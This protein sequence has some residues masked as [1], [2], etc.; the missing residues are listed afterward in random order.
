VV[1]FRLL[2]PIEVEGNVGQLVELGPPRQ[3]SVLAALAVDAGKLVMVDSLVDR[4]WGESP[5]ARVQHAIYSYV[6]RL[7]AILAGEP[8]APALVRRSRGYL[9]D[10]DPGSVDVHRFH[11]LLAQARTSR[12]PDPVRADLLRGGL[13]L[14][15][16]SPLAEMPGEWAAGLRHVWGQQRLEAVVLWAGIEL[17]TGNPAVVIDTLTG[18]VAEHPLHEP[19][20]C[21]LMRALHASGRVGDALACYATVRA[22]L[23]DE[24]GVDPSAELR[25]VHQSILDGDVVSR[26]P[27]VAAN[28]GG[29][30]PAQLPADVAGFTGRDLELAV[31]G[32]H[33]ATG[34]AAMVISAIAGTAGVGKTA[35]AVRFA[36]RVRDRFPDGQLH[37][38]LRGY[39]DN[40]PMGPGDV[41]AAFLRALGVPG[42]GI[43]A[44]VEERAA[45]YR[46]L[47]NG[48]RMV[49]LLDNASS[50]EQISPLL[51]GSPSCLVLVTSRDSLAGLVARHGARR[52]DLDVLSAREARA[53]LRG[54]VGTRVDAEPGAADAL[55]VQCGRL[56]LAL[57]VVAELA[58]TRQ[59]SSLAELAEELSDGRQRLDAFDVGSGIRAV[60]AF[61]YRQLP[62]E[63]ARAFRL[64]GL[65]PGVDV[66]PCAMAAL[67]GSDLATARQVLDVL[68][69][70][71]LVQRAGQ[72]RFTVHDLLRVYAAELAADHDSADVRLTALTG[73]FDHYL[74]TAVT[75]MNRLTPGDRHR[76][77]DLPDLPVPATPGP[78]LPDSAAALAWADAERENLVLSAAH[79]ATHGLPD[80]AVRFATILWRYL[81]IGGHYD[82]ALTL[83]AHALGAARASGDQAAEAT[84]LDGFGT[85]HYRRGDYP[86][87]GELFAEAVDL[88]RATG[89]RSGQGHLLINLGNVRHLQGRLDEAVD[90]YQRALALHEEVG[91]RLG[92]FRAHNNL[93]NTR[94]AQGDYQRAIEHQTEALVIIREVGDRDGEAHALDELGYVH[95]RLG[96]YAAA[97]EVCG[98]A[99]DAYHEVSSPLG[100]AHVLHSLGAIRL[101]Q[102]DLAAAAQHCEQALAGFRRMGVRNAEAEALATLGAIAAERG[103]LDLAAEHHRASLALFGLLGSEIGEASALN[104]LG[105][106]SL[107]AGKT[108]DADT[109]HSAALTIAERVGDRYEQARA[110]A[111]LG[112]ALHRNNNPV[113]ARRHW[114]QALRGF[115]E[116]GV[117]D[118]EQ[119]RAELAVRAPQ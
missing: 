95:L 19:L 21:A 39:D 59:G 73:L 60:F 57:R 4:V 18:L 54:L 105:A 8:S 75:A 46:T 106:V 85:V 90:S 14:W 88:C 3:R 94:R 9:L 40:Q 47:L 12:D 76:R 55:A 45:V 22:S 108:A 26:P 1:K 111:G 87:A 86:R 107:S 110:H 66:D 93:G 116:L 77:P 34:T 71:H 15:R 5:P 113:R 17:R 36:H 97:A 98:Q 84:V 63:A 24:L 33:L 74:H 64:L 58:V 112:H 99:L 79:A 10:A 109:E 51:P 117:P 68:A 82:D 44:G 104:N 119:L 53:L 67:L 114:D 62:A 27:V 49:I 81:D 38:D 43:P 91:D 29:R 48:R 70:A 37:V 32:E 52:L 96:D 28:A 50:V 78:E 23:A 20:T 100:V 30:V 56:P 11:D 2:G 115:D 42:S 31:L 80:H 89:D 16:G 6:A 83:H 102:G 35:L 92:M 7:R 65:H 72:R 69:R 41:L 118:A 61:S 103:D 13:D 25:Q 101:K